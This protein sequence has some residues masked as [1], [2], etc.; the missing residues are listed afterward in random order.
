MP[1]H[2]TNLAVLPFLARSRRSPTRKLMLLLPFSATTH[3]GL[4]SGPPRLLPQFH[5]HAWWSVGWHG[6]SSRLLVR[7]CCLR[8][9]FLLASVLQPI[10]SCCCP[11]RSAPLAA[12]SFR[13]T[14]PAPP[15]TDSPAFLLLRCCLRRLKPFLFGDWRLPTPLGLLLIPCFIYMYISFC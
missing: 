9:C 10:I 11:R 13:E 5:F 7:L 2:A 4:L 6:S 3:H 8:I 15:L 1:C 14:S 12:S